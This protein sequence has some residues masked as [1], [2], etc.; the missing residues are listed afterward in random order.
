MD[1]AT[2]GL[3]LTATIGMPVIASSGLADIAELA[4]DLSQ[5]ER[6]LFRLACFAFLAFAHW[7][8]LDPLCR[9]ER[10]DFA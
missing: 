5:V 9:R 1:I 8:A 2:I 6:T 7:R 3:R 10:A 4:V